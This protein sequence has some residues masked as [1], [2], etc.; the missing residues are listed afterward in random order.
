MPP[1]MP[2]GQTQTSMPPMPPARRFIPPYARDLDTGIPEAPPEYRAAPVS[3][4]MKAF[5]TDSRRIVDFLAEAARRRRVAIVR[6]RKVTGDRAIVTRAIEPYSIRYRMPKSRG[7]RRTRY[8][9]GYCVNGPT[10]GIHSFLA[11]NFES[12]TA[13][14][15]RFSPRWTVEFDYGG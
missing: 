9:F 4:E 1:P 10:I 14:T 8:L 13:T 5:E 7:Y 15:Q 6:Y 12:A 3:K 11:D 2:P